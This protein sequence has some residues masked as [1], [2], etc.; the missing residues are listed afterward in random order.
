MSAVELGRAVRAKKFS[1]TEVV[2]AHIER[3]EAVNGI[4]NAIVWPL[5][6]EALDSARTADAILARTPPTELGALF[7]VPVTIKDQFKIAGT[8]TSLGLAHRAK[9]RLDGEGPLVRRLRAAGTIFL[10]KTNLPQMLLTHECEHGAYGHCRNPFDLERAPGGSSGGEAAIIAAGGSPAGLGGDMG[11]SIRVPA[12]CTGVCGLKPTHGRLPN[13]DSLLNLD[14]F[15]AF[16]GFEGFAVQPGPMSR[17]VDDLTAMFRCLCDPPV[18]GAALSPPLPWRQ[19]VDLNTARGLRVGIYTDNGFFAPSRS[20]RRTVEEAGAALVDLGI[21]VIP[22][23]IPGGSYSME[24]AYDLLCAAGGTWL[25]R[26]LRGERPTVTNAGLLRS[27]A[28]PN[29]MRPPMAAALRLFGQKTAAAMIEHSYRLDAA[30][31]WR[32]I[33]ARTAYRLRFLDAMDQQGLHALVCPA[34]GLPA[35]LLDS[36][37]TGVVSL[38]GSYSLLYNLL[39]MPAGTVAAGRVREAEQG[40]RQPSRDGVYR[41]ARRIDEGSVGL[42]VGVQVAGRHYREDVVL[43]IMKILQDHFMATA[44]Y[45]DATHTEFHASSG[46]G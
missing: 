12:H 35:P 15:D 45:P 24:L 19:P 31:Y 32:L 44:E 28:L 2:T 37:A 33:A 34:Y 5:F 13:E 46:A 22:F 7:G 40:H 20:V 16:A 27:M 17:S 21:E 42:P 23:S 43:G 39:G 3:I 25:R 9:E 8:P 41:A 29:F 30:A 38:A 1:V 11:G 4:L 18:S 26:A 10:G 36:N 6:D 14:S